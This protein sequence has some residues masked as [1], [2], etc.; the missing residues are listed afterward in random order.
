MK[1]NVFLP[2]GADF[3]RAEVDKEAEDIKYQARIQLSKLRS[4]D[5]KTGVEMKE[6]PKVKKQKEPKSY[7]D[8]LKAVQK[9]K[10]G[11]P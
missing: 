2:E 3:S 11:R 6:K 4:E 7:A 9:T 5:V 1:R 8:I 10:K